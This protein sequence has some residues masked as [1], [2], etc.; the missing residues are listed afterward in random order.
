M[1]Q[2]QARR[3]RYQRGPHIYQREPGGNWYA[4]LPWRPDGTSLRTRDRAEA[5]REFRRLVAEGPG[6]AAPADAV[7]GRVESTLP[8][9]A[10]AWLAAPHGWT[11]ETRRT[12]R[13]LVKAW[14]RWCRAKGLALPSEITAEHM[15]A[16]V[17]EREVTVSRR[18]INRGLRAVRRM[19]AWA[20]ERELC[21][22]NE[23]VARRKYLRE[24]DRAD[25]KTVP[26]PA[27]MRR[28]LNAFDLGPTI[29]E[30]K[31]AG[32]KRSPRDRANDHGARLAVATIYAT[33]LRIAELQRLTEFDLYDSAVHV[34]PQEGPAAEAEPTKGYRQRAIP[35][36]PDVLAMVRAFCRWKAERGASVSEGWLLRKVHGACTRAKVDPCGLHDLRRAFATHAVRSGVD[37][38][39]VARWLG[40]SRVATT[41]RYVAAYR[42]DAKQQA[43]APDGLADVLAERPAESLPKAGVP[44][45]HA[46]SH[47]FSNGASDSSGNQRCGSDSNRRMEVLQT[48]RNGQIPEQS[49]AENGTAETPCRITRKRGAR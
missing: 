41:E 29:A 9:V 5:D 36:G 7:G 6:A 24:P 14:G 46:Q 18:T 28:V 26:D 38:V 3:R 10:K 27:E 22:P 20:A 19:F 37:L 1:S 23:A 45:G 39:V 43:P 17:S 40:H 32:W 4:Y 42:S 30:G 25:R 15:D 47:A 44:T 48:S 16:W 21:A 11:R 49:R 33:G 31:R 34:R 8:D 12:N 35:V 2:P 13:N